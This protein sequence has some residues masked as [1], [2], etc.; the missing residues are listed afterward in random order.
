MIG[1]EN[2]RQIVVGNLHD[3]HNLKFK[4]RQLVVEIGLL[5]L[6]LTPFIID[7]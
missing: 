6:V 7:S 2:I 1:K 5:N 4:I 3:L